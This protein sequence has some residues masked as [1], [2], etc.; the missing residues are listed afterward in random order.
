MRKLMQT[1]L[2]TG[3]VALL[4][5]APAKSQT[6]PNVPADP[7]AADLSAPAD[8]ADFESYNPDATPSSQT[9]A[10]HR[11]T[12]AFT[13]H[14]G[15]SVLISGMNASYE[16]A[17]GDGL[18]NY[19]VSGYLGYTEHRWTN[20]ILFTGTGFG[21]RRYLLERGAGTYVAPSLDILNVHRFRQGPDEGNNVLILAPNA[22]M[23]YRWTWNVFTMD[24]SCGVFYYNTRATSGRLT[25]DDPDK[26]GLLPMVQYA[27]G[28]PF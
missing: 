20:P 23:G 7:A 4:A 16:G 3:S 18:W 12:D 26:A 25:N 1:L 5:A 28:V 19:E 11:R 9:Q 21:V 15:F 27:L 17:L 14:P 8:V 10:A 22:R 6:L 2:W 13:I 24:V